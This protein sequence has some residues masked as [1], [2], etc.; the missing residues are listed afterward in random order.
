MSQISLVRLNG[1]NYKNLRLLLRSKK[2]EVVYQE[3]L[4]TVQVLSIMK[5]SHLVLSDALFVVENRAQ[6][7]GRVRPEDR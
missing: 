2:D 1:I 5:C 3:A 6:R 4:E 7:A